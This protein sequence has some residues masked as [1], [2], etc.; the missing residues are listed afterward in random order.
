MKI[1]NSL[2]IDIETQ[3]KFQEV[4]HD[5]AKLKVSV[6]GVYDYSTDKYRIYREEELNELF[7]IMEHSQKI[8]GYNINKF[9]LPVLAPYYLGNVKQFPTLDILELVDQS[10]GYRVAL[11]DLA[12]A[13]LSIKKSGHGLLAINYFREGD[14]ESLEKYCLDDVKI[15]KMLY[16]YIL[17][18]GKVLFRSANGIKEIKINL[19][20]KEEKSKSVSL[21]LPF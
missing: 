21:S 15:T 16:E 12:Q 17:K 18:N 20:L 2:V 14:W 9:D 8:I 19:P 1:N 13:T 11:N 7:K 3:H 5:L 6:V 10:L 4:N